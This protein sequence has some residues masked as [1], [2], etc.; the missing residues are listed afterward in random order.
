MLQSRA[1]LSKMAGKISTR[2]DSGVDSLSARGI[3]N[4]GPLLTPWILFE[5]KN[6]PSHVGTR[7][8]VASFPLSTLYLPCCQPLPYFLVCPVVLSFFFL[9]STVWNKMIYI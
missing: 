2:D 4:I 5:K 3:Q 6:T 8:K 9:C 1:G 7:Q